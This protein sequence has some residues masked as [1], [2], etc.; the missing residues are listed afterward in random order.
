M[1]AR[2]LGSLLFLFC[3]PQHSGMGWARAPGLTGVG[4]PAMAP[5]P[6]GACV[7]CGLSGPA[8]DLLSD[9]NLCGVGPRKLPGHSHAQ[10]NLSLAFISQRGGSHGSLS[11][12]EP[13]M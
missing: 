8:P 12:I 2:S 4:R 3:A 10:E 1:F 9:W 13:C 5:G 6:L 7:T 11:E